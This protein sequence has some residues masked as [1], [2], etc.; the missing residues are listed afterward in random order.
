MVVMLFGAVL[1]LFS[2]QARA[3]D[4]KINFDDQVTTI[5]RNS[6]LKCHNP[7]KTKGELDLST[8]AGL[9]KGGGS[10]K[11]VL[12]GDAAGSKLFKVIAR[13][14]EPFMPDKGPK[15]SDA[16][17]EVIQKWIAGG[18]VEKAGGKALVSNRPKIA[19][20]ST[21]GNSGKPEGPPALPVDWLQEPALH[22]ERTTAV[23]A[24]AAS[25]WSPLL[26]VGGVHQM[27]LYHTDSRQLAGVLPL[28]DINPACAQFS[29]NGKLL[30]VGGGRGAQFGVVE[31]YDVVTAERVARVGNEFDTVLAADLNSDQTQVVMGGPA[32]HVKIFSTR[33]GKLVYDLKKHTDWVTSVSFS[34]D[35]VLIASGDR[36]GGLVIW[37]ADTGQ[38]LYTLTGHQ[39]AI[40][41][42]S[43][44]DD[45][46]VLLSAS[47][48][49]TI[50]VW[51]MREG[52]E[53]GKWTAHGSG[54]LDARF[55]HDAKVA[56]CGR[57]RQISI[58]DSAGKKI[59]GWDA[60][61]DLPVR[62]TFSHDGSKVLT[63]TWE[64]SVKVWNSGDGKPLGEISSNPPPLATRLEA[65]KEELKRRQQAIAAAGET[66]T[67]RE[68]EAVKIKS[69]LEALDQSSPAFQY[70]LA[71]RQTRTAAARAAT[72]ARKGLETLKARA[73]K[74]TGD[75]AL[76][77]A[78]IKKAQETLDKT[79][80][81][82]ELYQQLT[83][84]LEVA[85][86]KLSASIAKSN[87]TAKL[88]TKKTGSLKAAADD[89]AAKLT[90]SNIEN[91]KASAVLDELSKKLE[92]ANQ[93][94]AV[95]RSALEK[96]KASVAREQ[97][98]L[99]Q[100][101][102]ALSSAEGEAEKLKN[103]LA[104]VEKDSVAAK[105]LSQ[106]LEVV[107][108]RVSE[109]GGAVTSVQRNLSEA[110]AFLEK[111]TAALATAESEVARLKM[112][113]ETAQKNSQSSH[114][115]GAQ[116]ETTREAA[117]QT[118]AK[119]LETLQTAMT[120]SAASVTAATNERAGLQTKLDATEKFSEEYKKATSRIESLQK[121]L[122]ALRTAAEAAQKEVAEV[123]TSV[124]KTTA[125]TA[126]ND[127]EAAKTMAVLIRNDAGYGHYLEIEKQLE[128]ANQK[129][130]EARTVVEKCR[131]DVA[132]TEKDILKI[133]LEQVRSELYHEKQTLAERQRNSENAQAEV[134]SAEET[135]A[136]AARE[137]SEAQARLAA[138]T[139]QVSALTQAANANAQK[140]SIA[141]ASA[142]ESVQ[143]LAAEKQQLEKVSA[144]F[145]RLKSLFE[146]N[147]AKQAK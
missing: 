105:E 60:G 84:Q 9:L 11:S 50:H 122:P 120:Q 48:D 38:E 40:T 112:A 61:P 133:N 146:G 70:A 45:S 56:S 51:E 141:K 107:G 55:S 16:E 129:V 90:A 131:Q 116:L 5:F 85:T 54:V 39:S 49:G 99:A 89:F 95:S 75:L 63:S 144:E 76:L 88:L 74:S 140:V 22:T 96:D 97:T 111:S 20:M 101:K 66:V 86:Q 27:L 18:L 17:I 132:G 87:E 127:A 57:D 113:M 103:S 2:E 25:P 31:I 94:V 65:A 139:Q 77:E 128:A 35:S 143:K 62:V 24:L 138:L 37:E 106:Q 1:S 147:P 69:L 30:I 118:G 58:W 109:A 83:K 135:D 98:A 93:M 14:E 142:S 53:V 125:T 44:R 13:T 92:L 130:A 3:V 72:E 19:A 102:T 47:E 108:K 126:A 4:D 21:A 123:Q 23:I 10:G 68:Q 81:F 52:R 59:K 41:S 12:P 104:S 15:M 46:E 91:T 43:W 110:M 145:Q 42:L 80:K 117:R 82:S 6:C 36:N 29:R 124:E 121:G 136:K 26:A 114:D 78:D 28:P 64:G 137:L 134:S 67:A 71:V 79:E 8:Y 73:T 115:R 100:N 34:P 7:D 119:E 32:R 33:D